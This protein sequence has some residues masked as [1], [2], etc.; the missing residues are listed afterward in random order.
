MPVRIVKDSLWPVIGYKPHKYQRLIHRAPARHK[1]VP[2]GRRFGKSFLGGHEL[3]PEILKTRLMA[4]ALK[5][6]GHRREFWIVGPEYSDSEKEFRVF[7]NDV[8]KLGIPLDKP[9]S[10]YNADSGHMVVLAW[11]GAFR[12]EAKSAKYPSTLVGE[13][14]SGVIL[15][16]AA[17]L[18]PS[19]W[20]KYIRPTLADFHGW[21]LHTSTPEGKNWFYDVYKRGQNPEDKEWWSKRMPS[22]FNPFAFP[23][24]RDDPEIR[25]MEGDMSREKFNQE[26]AASFTEYV[27]R[28]FKSYDPEIHLRPIRYNPELPLYI[29]LD[30]GWTNPFVCLLIQRDVWD[31]IYVIG[32][33]RAVNRD[34]NDIA[35]DLLVWRGGLATRAVTMYPDPASP[36]DTAIL[37][38]KL[39]VKASGDTGGEL[40]YRLEYIRQWL[41][42]G[43]EHA[44][45]HEQKPKL[46]FDHSCANAG[47]DGASLDYEMQEYRYPDNSSDTRSPKEE[48]LK[49]D[50]HAPE[51][52]GRFF[53][54]FYGPMERDNVARG[55]A[56]VTQAKVG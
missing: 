26:I 14:L 11:D 37:E 16:E 36:G 8:Q 33:Y 6:R 5:E 47:D 22:W 7:W 54:G 35:A 24:G 43:P 23:G 53:R 18:K 50:D 9:G 30:Y 55:R 34:I 13:G 19:V 1:V 25:D 28:V 10:Y 56:R 21:S 31:N 45:F 3:V 15:P 51:A 32:E 2:A 48:P 44:P 49:K 40:K 12:C 29:A 20:V 38:K 41:K 17:K 42:V 52:L 46:M 4:D 27:G 39:R